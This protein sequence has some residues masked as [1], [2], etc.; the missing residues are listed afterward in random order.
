MT[1]TQT[2]THE[3]DLDP[4][5]RAMVPV[6]AGL[7]V[8]V[9]DRDTPA[10]KASLIPLDT[11]QLRALCV[12]LAAMVPDTG[13]TLDLLEWTRTRQTWPATKQC[14]RCHEHKPR[15]QFSRDSYQRDGRRSDCRACDAVARRKTA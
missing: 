7:S 11:I 1:D 8:A 10:I 13:R 5:A 9:H 3:P 2:L 15:A 6:A 4:L 12:V 14:S